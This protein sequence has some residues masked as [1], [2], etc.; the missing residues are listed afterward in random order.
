MPHGKE[1]CQCRRHE[2]NP[3]SRKNPRA[4]EEL[5]LWTKTIEPVLHRLGPQLLSPCSATTEAW[6]P[7]GPRSI[8]REAAATRRPGTTTRVLPTHRNRS[9]PAQQQGPSTAPT[10]EKSLWKNSWSPRSA[11][12]TRPVSGLSSGRC[13]PALTGICG[14]GSELACPPV[15]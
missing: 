9:T 15:D 14:V 11:V 13:R 5:R 2:L 8:A 4:S 7:W 10:Q 12:P 6:G 3:W 1:S